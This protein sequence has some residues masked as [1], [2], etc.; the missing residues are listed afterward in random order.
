MPMMY[1][2]EVPSMFHFTSR[3][4]YMLSSAIVLPRQTNQSSMEIYKMW[5]LSRR[6]HSQHTW[7]NTSDRIMDPW[8]TDSTIVHVSVIPRKAYKLHH[9]LA[10][11]VLLL[12]ICFERE[13]SARLMTTIP[14]M[15]GESSKPPLK[16]GKPWQTLMVYPTCSIP[17]MYLLL[18]L[19]RNS[20]T[21]KRNGSTQCSRRRLLPTKLLSLYTTTQAI[22]T[23][24]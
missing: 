12:L 16:N 6:I 20:S 23:G 5:Q 19:K 8:K 3:K 17:R 21:N 9:Q 15:I 1:S 11:Q 18:L 14:L 22:V 4:L 13:P 10:A 2:R 7:S 24:N